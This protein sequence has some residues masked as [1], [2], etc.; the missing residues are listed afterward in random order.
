ML[1]LFY[2]RY[3]LIWG[4][5]IL[6]TAITWSVSFYSGEIFNLKGQTV[7]ILLAFV[8]IRL[9]LWN[10]MEVKSSPRLLRVFCDSW[11]ILTCGVFLVFLGF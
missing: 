3:T 11:I 8:K 10:F 9:V 4:L 6:L 7:I 1:D 2:A 5:L